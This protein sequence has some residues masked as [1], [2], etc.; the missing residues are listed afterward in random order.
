METGIEET[1]LAGAGTGGDEVDG[2]LRVGGPRSSDRER[3]PAEALIVMQLQ[4]RDRS[5]RKFPGL[6]E[7]ASAS[8]ITSKSHRLFETRGNAPASGQLIDGGDG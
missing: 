3:W 7:A 4:Q 1:N 2:G 8:T 6:E 5:E